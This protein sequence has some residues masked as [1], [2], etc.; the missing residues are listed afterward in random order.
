MNTP[1]EL[2]EK[3]K[4]DVEQR[5]KQLTQLNVLFINFESNIDAIK[6]QLEEIANAIDVDVKCYI[7]ERLQNHIKSLCRIKFDELSEKIQTETSTILKYIQ[8][9]A[10]AMVVVNLAQSVETTVKGLTARLETL[11]ILHPKSI[12]I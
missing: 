10:F 9:S 12:V 4:T 6:T 7:V 3:L 11:K 8:N 5:D 2:Y 1:K